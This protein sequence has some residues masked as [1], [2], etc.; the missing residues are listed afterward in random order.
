MVGNKLMVP[1][2]LA[3]NSLFEWAQEAVDIDIGVLCIN[4]MVVVSYTWLG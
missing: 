1:M 3:A 2:G 4:I